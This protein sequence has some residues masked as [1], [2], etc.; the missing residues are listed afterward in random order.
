MEVKIS[1]KEVAE[2]IAEQVAQTTRLDC[3][4]FHK[5]QRRSDCLPLQDG[6]R[7]G[8]GTLRRHNRCRIQ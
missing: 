1:S 5:P 6:S 2:A 3:E 8:H 7:T 4:A